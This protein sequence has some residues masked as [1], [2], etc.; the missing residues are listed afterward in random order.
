MAIR[1]EDKTNLHNE[2]LNESAKTATVSPDAARSDETRPDMEESYDEEEAEEDLDE[3]V[4][5]FN[6]LLT[7]A[8]F[9][10]I[11]H[12]LA[13]VSVAFVAGWMVARLFR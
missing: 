6:E 5:D 11:D 8:E 9:A 7:K 13:A 4:G 1:S 12:P 3:A 2:A 10:I